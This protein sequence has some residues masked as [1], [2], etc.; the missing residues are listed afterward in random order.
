VG[1]VQVARRALPQKGGRFPDAATPKGKFD[2]LKPCSGQFRSSMGLPCHHDLNQMKR[3]G[4]NLH[5]SDIYEFWYH[6]RPSPLALPALL[7]LSAL[8]RLPIQP[9]LF[10]PL[11][12]SLVASS[13]LQNPP[14]Q[15]RK[16][17]PRETRKLQKHLLN[18]I[19]HNSN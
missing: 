14:I 18:D 13:S 7:T 6:D 9:S 16:G 12:L 8:S 1:R 2:P 11:P 17:R 19:Y 15:A 5:L 3:E 4:R 10:D